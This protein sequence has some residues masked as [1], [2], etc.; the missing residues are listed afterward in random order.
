MD[1]IQQKLVVVFHSFNLLFLDKSIKVIEKAYVD[2]E[3][4]FPCLHLQLKFPNTL[5]SSQQMSLL[6]IQKG[7]NNET[8][9]DT[10]RLCSSKSS[11][12]P[13]LSKSLTSRCQAYKFDAKTNNSWSTNSKCKSPGA[14]GFCQ[15]K[16]LNCD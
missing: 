6:E 8:T 4:T 16:A 3:L 2:C 7:K 13:I 15:I 14:T 5:K 1:M 12:Q 9:S 10:A 11:C